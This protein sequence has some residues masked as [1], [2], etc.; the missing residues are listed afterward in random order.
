MKTKKTDS[1][2]IIELD[3]YIWRT[4]F[5][6]VG[7]KQWCKNFDSKEDVTLAQK[8]LSQFIYFD[9]VMIRE[10]LISLY[11]DLVI[12]PIK[13]QI[14]SN[15]I[16][17]NIEKEKEI[18]K[19]RFLGM[20]NPSE[21]GTLLLYYF[22]QINN[23]N[24]NLFIDGSSSK[25]Q[26]NNN[27]TEIKR[28]IYIDDMSITGS[29]IIDYATN[30]KYTITA[31][32]IKDNNPKIKINCYLLFATDTALEKI[33]ELKIFNR[34]ESVFELDGSFNCFSEDPS[35]RYL[36]TQNERSK[37]KTMLKK[38]MHNYEAGELEGNDRMFGFKE[39][40]L[41]LGLNHNTPNNTLPIFWGEGP[42]WNP[43][44]IRYGKNYAQ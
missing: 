7:I 36:K 2:K 11:R 44:F 27:N 13:Q 33:K 38:Y 21:S 34:V 12:Y 23:I 41:L 4:N 19:T 16:V 32:K 14:I 10:M 29:Q 28:Y 25:V 8:L 9:D 3:S 30:E 20:G 35:S 5:K 15:G 6:D 40:G 24:K 17:S 18:N 42:K 1:E 39:A 26:L 37:V 22:R 43:L 31:K